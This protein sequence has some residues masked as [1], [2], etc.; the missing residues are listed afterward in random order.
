MP[1]PIVSALMW[2]PLRPGEHRERPESPDSL[3]KDETNSDSINKI[4]NRISKIGLILKMQKGKFYFK[5]FSI[6]KT[7]IEFAVF[8]PRNFRHPSERN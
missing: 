5:R 8:R 1:A 6:L 2:Q 4:R 3:R 7:D